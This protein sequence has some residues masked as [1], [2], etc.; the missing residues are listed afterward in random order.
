[1]R[2]NREWMSFLYMRLRQQINLRLLFAFRP[3]KHI[4][5]AANRM[6]PNI[7][8]PQS[9]SS[10]VVLKHVQTN[11]LWDDFQVEIARDAFRQGRLE[12]EFLRRK[13]VSRTVHPAQYRHGFEIVKKLK[14]S[15]FG[16]KLLIRVQESPFGHPYLIPSYPLLSSVGAQNLYYIFLMRDVLEIDCIENGCSIVDFGGGYGFFA[17]AITILNESSFVQVI[18][19]PIMT[20][21]QAEYHA[22]SL[23]KAQQARIR[24]HNSISISNDGLVCDELRQVFDDQ[25]FHFSATFSLSE[26]GIEV[27]QRI[28]SEIVRRSSSFLIA[29]QDK[30]GQVDNARFFDQEFRALCPQHKM[31][32]KN[33]DGNPFAKIIMGKRE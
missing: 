28:C 2:S 31:F 22:N 4:F 11:S 20:S 9:E 13:S 25:K 19:L 7:L 30:F 8:L 16:K 27:R 5:D 17:R 33:Y 21:I 29:F 24:Y 10:R 14:G 3:I 32:L 26:C 15:S 6:R 23:T 18:D 12:N 1:M